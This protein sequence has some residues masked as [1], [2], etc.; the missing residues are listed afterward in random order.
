[1]NRE[2]SSLDLDHLIIVGDRVLIRLQAPTEKTH[3][4]LYLPPGVQEKEPVQ[5]GYVIKVGPGQPLPYPVEDQPWK[6]QDESI[7]YLPLQAQPGDL[8]IFLQNGSYEI[9]YH[10]QS[11]WVVPHG[12][13]LMLERDPDWWQ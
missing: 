13:I 9:A 4:G 7:R 11:F 5:Y 6:S 10:G 8:A 3:S 2:T 1:M 12:A